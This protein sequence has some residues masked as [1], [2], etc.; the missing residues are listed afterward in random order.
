MGVIILLEFYLEQ[1]SNVS[2]SM[3]KAILIYSNPNWMWE[4]A[5]LDLKKQFYK[6]R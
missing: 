3:V 4:P 1:V 6:F 5:A 2:E